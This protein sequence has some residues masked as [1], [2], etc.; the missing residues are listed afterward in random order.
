MRIVFCPK[1]YRSLAYVSICLFCVFFYILLK[2]IFFANLNLKFNLSLFVFKYKNKWFN[3]IRA[4]LYRKILLINNLQFNLRMTLK[5][6]RRKVQKKFCA[7]FFLAKKF[8]IFSNF[9]LPKYTKT[10]PSPL[11]KQN[12]SQKILNYPKTKY[13]PKLKFKKQDFVLMWKN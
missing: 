13:P 5:S 12:F 1:K 6:F 8:K 2:L 3:N 9:T 10:F 7:H 11:K 4:K